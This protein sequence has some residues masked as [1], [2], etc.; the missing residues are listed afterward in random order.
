MKDVVDVE[1][2]A[3]KEAKDVKEEIKMLNIMIDAFFN[4]KS[5]ITNQIMIASRKAPGAKTAYWLARALDRG[6]TLHSNY[7]EVKNNIIEKYADHDGSGAIIVDKS[8]NVKFADKESEENAKKEIKELNELEVPFGINKV[9]IDLDFIQEREK[10]IND[11]SK[12]FTTEDMGFL[13]P[14]IEEPK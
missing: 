14:F 7:A 10:K 5:P 1:A 4:P 6:R 2:V 9:T 3:G 8:G 11:A 12:L 13:L